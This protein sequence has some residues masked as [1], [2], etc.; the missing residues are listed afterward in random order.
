MDN[1]IKNCI[2]PALRFVKDTQSNPPKALYRLKILMNWLQKKE[3]DLSLLSGINKHLSILLKQRE[4]VTGTLSTNWLAQEAIKPQNVNRPGTFRKFAVR[5]LEAKIVPVLAGI[6]AF[7]DTNNNLGL[8]SHDEIWKTDL[9]LRIM[10]NPFLT[11]LKYSAIA[12][13]SL[14]Q[15]MGEIPVKTTALD[16][17]MFSACMPFSWLIFL[18]IDDILR[19]TIDISQKEDNDCDIVMKSSEIF[20]SLP[21][22]EVLTTYTEKYRLEV[23][24]AF[25]KDL[26]YMVYP[27]KSDTECKLI[28]EQVINGC[29]S[30]IQAEFGRLIPS[31]FGCHMIFIRHAVR[32]QHFSHIIRIRQ[33]RGQEIMN[34]QQNYSNSHL[35]TDE[36]I[37]LDIFALHM[38]VGQL[39]TGE[40]TFDNLENRMIWLREVCE[41]RPVVERVFGHFHQDFKRKEKNYGTRSQKGIEEIRFKWNR[42]FIVKMFLTM[43][44]RIQSFKTNVTQLWTVRLTIIKLIVSVRRKDQEEAKDL[45]ED[46]TVSLWKL[47]LC[48]VLELGTPPSVDVIDKLLTYITGP[49]QSE[50]AKK[51]DQRS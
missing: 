25:I 40:R 48:S 4:Q 47:Y 7:I 14:K 26:V 44:A 50:P 34:M 5:C 17:K 45:E 2:Q 12:S 23:L 16:G 36:E 38:L 39:D 30:L 13:S 37:T 20:Q 3:D 31:M 35:I 22:G 41:Y 28:S 43:S 29:R 51:S 15:E 8:L 27:V 18:Q 42:A 1:L 11:Q 32:F 6:I 21:L 10:N 19:K 49:G 46:V 33:E 9:W 24:Q